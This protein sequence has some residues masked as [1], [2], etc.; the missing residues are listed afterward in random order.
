MEQSASNPCREHTFTVTGYSPHDADP[1]LDM[2]ARECY[3]SC[4]RSR[5]NHAVLP[6]E[7]P[8]SRYHSRSAEKRRHMAMLMQLS[9]RGVALGNA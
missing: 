6:T 4:S 7:Q 2:P 8:L 9:D 3:G 5:R 1:P